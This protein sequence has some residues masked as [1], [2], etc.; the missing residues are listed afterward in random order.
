MQY[1]T[2]HAIDWTEQGLVP[3]LMIRRGI[4]RLLRERLDELAHKD[5]E[6]MADAQRGFVRSM[7]GAPIA[8]LPHKANEQHYEV[9]AA[10]F[11]R[12]L[13]GHMKYSCCYWPAGIESLD[14]AEAAALETT[15][16]HAGIDN[17]MD[18]LELGC[19]WGSLTLWMAERYPDS[20]ITA[21]S[22][23]CSQHDQIL[24]EAR[25][26]GLKNVRVITADMNDFSTDRHFDRVVSVEMFEHMR[27]YPRLFE[28]IAG[29]LRP[30]GRFFMHIFCHR[31][32]PY[33]FVD[34]GAGDWMSRYF[35]S[36]GIM[37]SDDLPLHFQRD[38]Q[39]LQRWRWS[40][41]HYEKTANAWL[42][43]MDGARDELWPL[44]EQVYGSHAV[45]QW[46]MRWRMF[47][48]AC[49]E[50]FGHSDGQEW[51]VSHYLFEKL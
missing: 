50:L 24:S 51:F 7:R 28:R 30:R 13:G 29:W 20:T 23:S 8:P 16:A 9:P 33:A 3:D 25:W 22:N 45:Q 48:M 38:L 47:F 17:G 10:F 49:A 15:C 26:R 32:V 4:R 37:P 21:V 43:R 40:G 19:G 35:F 12:V 14:E 11:A 5:V 41:S 1:P 42:A 39:L 44:L 46:W 2:Q 18:V 31:A 6:T 36:G 27:N 34:N